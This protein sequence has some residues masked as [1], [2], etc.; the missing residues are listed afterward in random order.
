LVITFGTAITAIDANAR[1]GIPCSLALE[2]LRASHAAFHTATDRVDAATQMLTK[3]TE[4]LADDAAGVEA[5]LCACQLKYDEVTQSDVQV[6]RLERESELLK[7]QIEVLRGLFDAKRTSLAALE[8]VSR[9]LAALVGQR[10]ALQGNDAD[11]VR[12]N[13]LI[14]Q[15]QL[16]YGNLYRDLMGYKF[17]LEKARIAGIEGKAA[18]YYKAINHHDDDHERIDALTFEKM[19]KTIASRL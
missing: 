13:S 5:Y 19:E 7:N 14:D 3:F 15:L 10:A 1:L 18:E 11:N 8:E 16:E 6:K 12:F 4:L 17:K 9:Q 2:L